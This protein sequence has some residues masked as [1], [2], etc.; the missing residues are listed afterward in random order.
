MKLFPI[1]MMSLA[2]FSMPS[3]GATCTVSATGVSLGTYT[4]NQATPVD[5]AGQITVACIKGL[6]D[7]LGTTVNYSIDISKGGSSSYSPRELKSGANALHYNL[8]RDSLRTI[9]WGDNT[10][11]TSSLTGSLH[12]PLLPGAASNTHTAYSRIFATQNAVPGA[13]VDTL[14]ITVYY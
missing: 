3:F 10:G 4:P 2:L 5:S 9:I 7:I 6:F 11:G 14:F 12:I 1:I 8:Y 13:Y